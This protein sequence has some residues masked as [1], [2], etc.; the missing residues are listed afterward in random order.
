MTIALLPKRVS[1]KSMLRYWNMRLQN[2]LNLFSE[3]N[4]NKHINNCIIILISKRHLTTIKMSNDTKYD[5][6]NLV[7]ALPITTL[8]HFTILPVGLVGSFSDNQLHK[9]SQFYDIK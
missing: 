9:T 6:T 8:L 7:Y 1:Y 2:N 5:K 4:I 3:R